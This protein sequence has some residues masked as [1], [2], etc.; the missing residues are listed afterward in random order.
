M[1]SAPRA[2]G[3]ITR[4]DRRR[5]LLLTALLLAAVAAA[6]FPA[7]DGGRLLDDDLHL[8]RPELQSAAGLG[9]IWFDLGA[10]Q[11][12]YPVVH[13]AFWLEHRLWGDAV[14]GYHFSN[15]LLHGLAA[16]LVVRL[17]RRLA[18][19]GAWLAAFLFALHPVCVE[20]VAWMAEQKNTLS[21]VL[22]LGAALTYLEFSGPRS[23]GRYAAAL[24]LFALAL[25]SKT[26]VVTLPALLLV[27]AWWRSPRFEWRREAGFLLPWFALAGAVSLATF[28]LER[29]LMAGVAAEF[30]LSP[31]ARVLL[32]GRA[33]WFYLGRLL[34]PAGLTFIYPR[35]TLD[36]AAAWQYGY[37]LAALAL[38]VALWRRSRRTRG[39]LAAYLCFAGALAPV[40]GFFNMEWFVFSYVADHLGYLACLAASLPAAAAL[41]AGAGRLPASLRRLAP[42]AGVTLV[43]ALGVLTW[44]QSRRYTDPVTFYRTAAA[45]NPQAAAAYENLG[46][47]LAAM[48]GRLDEAIAQIEAS[49]RVTPDVPQGH[50]DLGTVLLQDPARRAEA[51][52]QFAE[53]LRLQP[54]RKSARDKLALALAGIP[55]R[56]PEAIAL[57]R[58]SLRADPS[59]PRAHDGLGVALSRTPGRM[60]E[61]IAEY[62]EALRLQP[63]FAE[64]HND[65]GLALAQTGRLPDAIAEFE[66]AVRLKPGFA[67]GHNNLGLAWTLSPGRMN[68][69]IAEFRE[70]VRL[71]PNFV[72]A[73]HALGMACLRTGDLAAAAEAFR[74][75]LRL[76]PASAGA[77]QALE[78][79]LQQGQRR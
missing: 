4:P 26:A 40:L 62:E 11:Q 33:F 30:P 47:V 35:W 36:P 27:L 39:P 48:P 37:P 67:G 24:G 6:Y 61:A 56:L 74:Q 52:A 63:D 17:A 18:L 23:R 34:W 70:T 41:I 43:L 44:R 51:A 49:L 8:T 32:A 55:G 59:D 66:T 25:L 72:P 68:E 12:Y 64:A 38:G 69:A 75:E 20:S 45:L 76:S 79:V 50:E 5:D 71:D 54:G 19:P 57:Y 29:R 53:S 58:E 77:R 73:W 78:Q 22:A 3:G 10:T 28:S 7:R 16:L 1:E 14:A 9:R 65:L 2:L 15:V 46:M 42:A 60:G 21:T 13:T 31:L